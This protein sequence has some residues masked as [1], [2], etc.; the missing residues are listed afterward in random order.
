MHY[1][2]ETALIHVSCFLTESIAR[3]KL[4][5]V[6]LFF[7][8]CLIFRCWCVLIEEVIVLAKDDCNFVILLMLVVVNKQCSFHGV[9]AECSYQ[10]LV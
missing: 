3:K 8:I 4:K 5:I 9:V 7:S 10:S 1:V 6:F 2:C